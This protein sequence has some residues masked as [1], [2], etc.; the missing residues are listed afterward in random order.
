VN[1]QQRTMRPRAEESVGARRPVED[2]LAYAP[3]R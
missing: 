2:L 1:P 3:G